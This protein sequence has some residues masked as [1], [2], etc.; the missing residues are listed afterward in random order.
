MSLEETRMNVAGYARPMENSD[1]VIVNGLLQ[2]PDIKFKESRP[3]KAGEPLVYHGE[4][5]RVEG[6]RIEV[7][8]TFRPVRLRIRT[9]RPR[10]RTFARGGGRSWGQGRRS[11][12]T[13]EL[14]TPGSLKSGIWNLQTSNARNT[15][16]LFFDR[17]SS[18]LTL[19]VAPSS[20]CREKA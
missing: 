2:Q 7:F 6:R 12:Q 13:S 5:F 11:P 17:F 15:F 4:S 18:M 20:E 3:V 9:I 14:L 10:S 1:S 8:P 16:H 19:C